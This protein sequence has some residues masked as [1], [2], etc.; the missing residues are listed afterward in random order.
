[1]LPQREKGRKRSCLSP[2]CHCANVLFCLPSLIRTSL[3][4]RTAFWDV[5]QLRRFSLHEDL[6]VPDRSSL[7][8]V[9]L[10]LI[11]PPPPTRHYRSDDFQNVWVL[12][13]FSG[14]KFLFFQTKCFYS[15]STCEVQNSASKC[16][17]PSV[18][19]VFV[20]VPGCW[21]SSLLRVSLVGHCA[22]GSPLCC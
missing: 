15:L 6:F 20:F 11:Y 2:N 18:C 19:P 12:D 21:L 3:L 4:S 5:S 17:D 22:A 13:R 8:S 14:V 7:F 9:S 16:S 1:M 10:R